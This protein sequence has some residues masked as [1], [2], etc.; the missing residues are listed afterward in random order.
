MVF[1]TYSEVVFLLVEWEEILGQAHNDEIMM[2][3]TSFVSFVDFYDHYLGKKSLS[4]YT[5]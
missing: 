3:F 5:I 2:S 1:S 4:I